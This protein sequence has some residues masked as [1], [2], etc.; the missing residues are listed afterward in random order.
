MVVRGL[1]WAMATELPSSTKIN[2]VT[3]LLATLGRVCR[4]PS[5][6]HH[7]STP[8]HGRTSVADVG[9]EQRATFPDEARS[10]QM[11]SKPET[12]SRTVLPI[13]DRPFTG[14]VMFDAKDP[15]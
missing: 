9:C 10:T 13:P 15:N 11:K 6:R 14:P 4:G 2:A 5:E 1:S 3:T 8:G 7:H 12:L